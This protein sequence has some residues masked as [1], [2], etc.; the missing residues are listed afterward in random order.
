MEWR[1]SAIIVSMLLTEGT[2]RAPWRSSI[3]AGWSRSPTSSRTPAASTST[4][5]VVQGA[6]PPEALARIEA[7]IREG[8]ART[9]AAADEDGLTPLAAAFR[10]GREF[11]AAAGAE[12]A[13]LDELFA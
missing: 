1:S 12:D 10:S 7:L 13:L 6:S 11:L 2:A 9:L 5:A 4:R 8:V 3:A